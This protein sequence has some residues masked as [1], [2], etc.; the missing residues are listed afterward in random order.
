M[1]RNVY[2]CWGNDATRPDGGA[3]HLSVPV[4]ALPAGAGPALRRTSPSSL[5][6]GRRVIQ[7][8]LSIFYMDNH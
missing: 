1:I 8:P 7:T 6:T 5:A 4:L 3:D 2:K